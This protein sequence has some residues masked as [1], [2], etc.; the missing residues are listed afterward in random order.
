MSLGI[1]N[2][3]SDDR[4]F[5]DSLGLP[6]HLVRLDGGVSAWRDFLVAQGLLVVRHAVFRLRSCRPIADLYHPAGRTAFEV[7]TTVRTVRPNFRGSVGWYLR[8][9]EEGLVRR[10]VCVRVRAEPSLGV[11]DSQKTMLRKAG[12]KLVTSMLVSKF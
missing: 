10:V 2:P 11:S 12:F 4:H 7:K 8:L 9:R 5:A 3:I 1:T 6:R